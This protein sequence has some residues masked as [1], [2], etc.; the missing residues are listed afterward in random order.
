M[1]TTRVATTHHHPPI[2]TN[3]TIIIHPE[4]PQTS[5]VLE[6]AAPCHGSSHLKFHSPPS[7]RKWNVKRQ[8]ENQNTT[9]KKGKKDE[10]CIYTPL[11]LTVHPWKVVVK[12]DSRRNPFSFSGRVQTKQLNVKGKRLTWKLVEGME[13]MP[14]FFADRFQQGKKGFLPG[15]HE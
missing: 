14:V 11:E 7:R 5:L 4:A 13:Y 2:I 8:L 3:I 10:N 9:S 12:R 6:L 15:I 1:T